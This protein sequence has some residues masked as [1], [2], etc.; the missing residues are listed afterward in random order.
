MII[1]NLLEQLIGS[2][3]EFERYQVLLPCDAL[4]EARDLAGQM[5]VPVSR[6]LAELLPAALTQARTEW[7]QVCLEHH[8]E[9]DLSSAAGH[10]LGLG[11]DN[12]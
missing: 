12:H 11:L 7:R 8:P 10:Y 4:E 5:G 2:K 6:L 3:T 9:D 1:A